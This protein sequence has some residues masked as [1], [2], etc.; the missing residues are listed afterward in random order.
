MDN[1]GFEKTRFGKIMN[2]DLTDW[3][4]W[5]DAAKNRYEEELDNLGF[6]QTFDS[7]I[8]AW[9]FKLPGVIGTIVRI[10]FALMPFIFTNRYEPYPIGNNEDVNN[11][12]KGAPAF[13][14][15]FRWHIR[16]L[17]CDLRKFYL[18]FAYA[19]EVKH[20]QHKWGKIR[21]ARFPNRKRA[22]PFPVL[23]TRFGHIGWEQRG[24]LSGGLK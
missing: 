20:V 2:E 16:N 19:E 23:E 9:S 6:W 22:L 1:S 14:R 4:V 8:V 7:K 3:K 21:W 13:W 18:G 5:H 11:L 24:I 12:Y 17:Y 10:F 15:W